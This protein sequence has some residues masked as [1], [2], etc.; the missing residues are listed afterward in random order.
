[1]KLLLDENISRRILPMRIESYPDSSH[2]SLL[3]IER[4]DDRSI[5]RFAK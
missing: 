2:V 5:W 3:G 1:M 4:A